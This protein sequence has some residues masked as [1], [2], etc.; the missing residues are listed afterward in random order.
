MLY[1]RIQKKKAMPHFINQMNKGCDLYFEF[2]SPEDRKKIYK[3]LIQGFSVELP[4]F[5]EINGNYIFNKVKSIKKEDLG[6]YE[7]AYIERMLKVISKK[8]IL[9]YNSQTHSYEKIAYKVSWED[10]HRIIHAQF[11]EMDLEM[12]M[13]LLQDY[14][15]SIKEDW[16][17]ILPTDFYDL[18]RKEQNPYFLIDIRRPEDYQGGHISGAIN[19]FWLDILREDNFRKLPM[20]KEILV[21]CYVGHTSSQVMVILNLLGFKA[22]SLKFGM[23]INPDEKVEIK[24]WKDY[25]YPVKKGSQP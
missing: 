1:K 7:M 18:I 6:S 24:G 5:G 2:L 17:Y 8:V 19:I 10:Y 11:F 3:D 14:L 22:K 4:N 20:D 25:G 15:K 12:L 13:R 21:Y 9:K 16:N 23:G